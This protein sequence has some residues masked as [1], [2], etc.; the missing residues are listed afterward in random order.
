MLQFLVYLGSH[1]LIFY[2]LNWNCSNGSQVTPMLCLN[3][4]I[5]QYSETSGILFLNN[6]QW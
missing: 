5:V 2:Y 3:N 6:F 1:K 4:S